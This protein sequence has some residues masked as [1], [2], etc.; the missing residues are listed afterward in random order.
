MVTIQKQ[1]RQEDQ[2]AIQKRQ[3][4]IVKKIAKL[5]QWKKELS[6]KI[7]KKETDARVAKERKDRLVEEVRRHFGFKID[8][9]DERFKEMLEKKEKEEKKAQKE[10]KKKL[11]ETKMLE[12]LQSKDTTPVEN[13]EKS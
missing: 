11:R 2:D 8:A 12:R 9:R 13:V 10:A 3:D 7:I 5:D 6:D 1:K 4:D